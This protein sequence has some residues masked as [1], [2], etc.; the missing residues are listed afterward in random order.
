LASFADSRVVLTPVFP[1][2]LLPAVLRAPTRTGAFLCLTTSM[3]AAASVH[4]AL[5]APPDRDAVFARYQHAW[6]RALL[7]LFGV[8]IALA[9]DPTAAL[10]GARLVVANHRSTL[11]IGVLG[12]LFGGRL[13][14]RADVARWPLLGAAARAAGTIFVERG[15]GS[16]GANAVRA[17]RDALAAGGTI[18]LFPE[19]TTYGDDLVRPFRR[20][21]FAAAAA[22]RVPV[23]PVGL[24]YDSSKRAIFGDETFVRHLARVAASPALAVAVR[25]GE[26]IG[27]SSSAAALASAAH[28]AVQ[29]LVD[30]ARAD[31]AALEASG[32]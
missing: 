26:P 15:V 20:G 32:S 6:Y 24:A 8:R 13:L 5:V 14:S 1:A 29:A 12:W 21:A 17:I 22:A 31:C 18:A 16:S 30:A 7:D 10:A 28:E 25:I 11:D 2:A 27:P 19:G 4:R 23:V 3:L 9:G